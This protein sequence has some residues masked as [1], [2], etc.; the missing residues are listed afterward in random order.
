MVCSC[1]K[2]K[3]TLEGARFNISGN[4]R[5]KLL[6]P[7]RIGFVIDF[8]TEGLHMEKEP[9]GFICIADKIDLDGYPSAVP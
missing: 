1:P 7:K 3:Y 5:L 9:L 2:K 6:F 8:F 4:E